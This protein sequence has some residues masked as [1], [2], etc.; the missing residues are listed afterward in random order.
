MQ[1]LKSMFTEI[2]NETFDLSKILAALS[3]LTSIFLA[4]YSVVFRGDLFDVNSYGI[5]M[6]ALF[7][8][9]AALLKFKKDSG[10]GGNNL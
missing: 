7:A 2:D 1:F 8:G 6:A 4:I 3:V 5:G 10:D 9:T